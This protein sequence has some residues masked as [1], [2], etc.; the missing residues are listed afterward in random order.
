MGVVYR[1]HHLRLRRDVALKVIAPELAHDSDFRSRFE[2]ESELAASIDHP[3][4]IPIYD[5][6]E[7]DGVLFIAM[8]YV[9]GTDLRE[10][11]VREKRLAPVR[12]AMLLSQVA[13][14]LD[15]AHTAGLVHRD[16]KPGNILI[17]RRDGAEHAYLTDFGLMKRAGGSGNGQ[18]TRTGVFVGTLDYAAPEQVAGERVDARTDVYALGCV[19]FQC[20]SGQVPFPRESDIAKMF[21]HTQEPAPSLRATAPDVPAALDAVVARALA[22]RPADRYPSAGD[23]GRA[24]AA[25]AAGEFPSRLQER[26]VAF[27]AAAP[28]NGHA[29]P[30]PQRPEKR[31]ATPT[32]PSAPTPVPPWPSPPPISSSE[33]PT[34]TLGPRR[35]VA[36]LAVVGAVILIALGAAVALLLGR[37]DGAQAPAS[38]LQPKTDSARQQPAP[39][40]T[41]E[42]T[43]AAAP[44]AENN[45][46]ATGLSGPIELQRFGS[47]DYGSSVEDAEQITGV[48]LQPAGGDARGCHFVAPEG[49]RGVQFMVNEGSIGRVD[50]TSPSYATPSGIRVGDS[51]RAVHA[52]YGGQLNEARSPYDPGGN[53]LTVVPKESRNTGYRV[54]LETDGQSV[55][56]IRAGRLPEVEFQEGCL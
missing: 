31:A 19:L 32:A 49:D 16:V 53:V 24:V 45:S 10:V 51:E 23:L 11:L 14:A 3:H 5:A 37:D 33:A 42:T 44:P 48:A 36:A 39:E 20:L 54:V 56:S 41:T 2:R 22:K 35:G 17:A 46:A 40:T 4:V 8:R 29:A 43:R 52:A 30:A 34:R 7:H 6:D 15:A 13:S 9:E 28:I 50:V 25:A 38:A 1:A 55:V 12:V 27:G 18:L 47:V 26:S 21:A